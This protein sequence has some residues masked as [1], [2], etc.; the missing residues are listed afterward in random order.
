[1]LFGR[2]KAVFFDAL[3]CAFGQ[4]LHKKHFFVKTEKTSDKPNFLW[5][6]MYLYKYLYMRQSAVTDFGGIFMAIV[7]TEAYFN[8][9]TGR[10]KIHTL[11]WKEEDLTPVGVF[12]I[13]HGMAEHI[14]RYDDFARFLAANGFVVCGNDHLGH[15][16]SVNSD[17]D[18]GYFDEYNGDKRLVDDMHILTKIMKKKYPDLPYFLFGH[19]MG[20]L[21]ARV[22][23]AHF[24]YELNGVIYCGTAELPAAADLLQPVFAAACEKFGAKADAHVLGNLF[25]AAGNLAAGEKNASPVA[26]ISKNKQNQENYMNDPLCG[27]PL[28]LGGYRDM[29]A[30]ACECAQKDWA[31]KVPE[32]LPVMI[33]SGANDPVG[34]NGKGTLSVADNLVLAGRDPTVILYPGDRHEVL[35]EDNYETVYNDVLSWLHSIYLA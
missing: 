24:G 11:I 4:N 23:T 16:K 28:C 20:S 35:F 33:F 10:N 31:Y 5:Y 7:K 27:F 3:P 21:C 32:N 18:Y 30:L 14:E 1:M 9:S 22:Y 8:S 12:Q 6:D 19:S 26:W 15:G 25:N 13:A 17:E 34:F 29:Y 2:E